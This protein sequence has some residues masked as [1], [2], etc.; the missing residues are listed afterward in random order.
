MEFYLYSKIIPC[1][2][3]IDKNRKISKR[4]LSILRGKNDELESGPINLL[5][6]REVSTEAHVPTPWYGQYR[7]HAQRGSVAEWCVER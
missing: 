7:T 6:G 5:G 3:F 4:L 2:A 1:K